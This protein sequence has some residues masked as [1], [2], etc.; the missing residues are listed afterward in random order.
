MALP[1]KLY[2][3]EAGMEVS[4]GKLHA[5]GHWYIC[6]KWSTGECTSCDSK[7]VGKGRSM[8]ETL[9]ADNMMEVSD[10]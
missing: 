5:D 8:V 9:P 1:D 10:E 7:N 3:P 2:C 6:V 4:D